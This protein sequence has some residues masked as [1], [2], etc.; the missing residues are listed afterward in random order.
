MRIAQ[1]E[2]K[3]WG[4]ELLKFLVAYRTTP[5]TTTGESP[6]KLL[7]G[8]EIHTKLP[9]LRSSSSG[10]A[11]DEDVHDKDRI[12]KQ[13]GKDYTDD[14]RNAQESGLQQGDRVLLKQ[15]KSN[16]LDTPFYPEPYKV[17][18]KRGSEV[19]AQS[20][21]G[22]RYRRNIT[23]VKKFHTESPQPVMVGV[24]EESGEAKESSP[25]PEPVLTCRRSM[26]ECHVPKHL[27]DYELR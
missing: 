2:K 27:E 18:D 1:A 21:I 7:Y 11:A 6:A 22:E 9:S 14:R 24:P 15:C 13:K 8:R 23:H 16:K 10:V 5:L 26:R 19:T 25:S 17:V 12:A 4:R 3:D 20:S